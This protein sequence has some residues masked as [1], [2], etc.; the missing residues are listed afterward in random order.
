MQARNLRT[1]HGELDLVVARASLLAGVLLV[2]VE[3]KTRSRHSAPE[4]LVD[5]GEVARRRATLAAIARKLMPSVRRLR[6]R[7]DVAA[8]RWPD[9]MAPEIRLFA[10]SESPLG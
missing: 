5:D 7:V 9:G 6:L 3:V 8:V 10:G 4:R 1:T 2:A